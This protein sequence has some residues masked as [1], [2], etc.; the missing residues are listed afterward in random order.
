MKVESSIKENC[1]STTVEPI[2][3]TNEIIQAI[4]EW[5]GITLSDFKN[6]TGIWHEIWKDGNWKPLFE[7]DGRLCNPIGMYLSRKYDGKSVVFEKWNDKFFWRIQVRA[8]INTRYQLWD[9][10][11]EIPFKIRAVN[12][13]TEDWMIIFPKTSDFIQ[14]WMKNLYVVNTG[15]A[16]RQRIE[17]EI[18]A[19]LIELTQVRGWNEIISTQNMIEELQTV[20]KK[21]GIDISLSQGEIILDFPRRK[22]RDTAWE[23]GEYMA[24]PIQVLIDF[25]NRAVKSKGYSPHGFGTPSSWWNPCWWNRDNDIHKCLRDCDLKAL[26]NLIVSWAYGYNSNDT[27]RYHEWRH[28]LAKLRDYIW[29]LKDYRDTNPDEVEKLKEHLEEVKADLNIDDWLES[30]WSIKEFLS[31]LETQTDETSEQW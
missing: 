4:C 5:N 20:L 26:I 29:W 1:I 27:G 24:S 2:T 14:D 21:R 13:D 15:W 3:D 11:V 10:V 30:N 22:L 19:K 9:K 6:V 7:S 12:E 28:P 17:K 25:D 16:E 23:D 8:D 31:S 18:I